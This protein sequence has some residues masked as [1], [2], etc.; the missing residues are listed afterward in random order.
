MAFP[1]SRPWQR[2]MGKALCFL[3]LL[4]LSV[5]G[6]ALFG[7]I[8]NQISYTVAPEYFHVLKFPQFGIPSDMRNR[9]GAGLV[10]V[11]ASWWMGVLIGVP[12]L[13]FTLCR[14]SGVAAYLR[15]GVTAIAL[16]LGIALLSGLLALAAMTALTPSEIAASFNLPRGV[17]DPVAFIRA[18][19]LHEGSYAGGVLGLICAMVYIHI[20]GRRQRRAEGQDA[21]RGQDSRSDRGRVRL[22][23]GDRAQ[24]RGGGRSGCRGGYQYRRRAA[25]RG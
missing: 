10:G 21:I 15:A 13:G 17:S 22:W 6:A 4:L 18:G 14:I 1:H 2:G 20:K 7:A 19:A 12:V 5:I 23:R 16:V 24:I 3:A 9:A 11:F 25:H 8:H